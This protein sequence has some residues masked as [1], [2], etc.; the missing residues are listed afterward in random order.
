MADWDRL[1]AQHPTYERLA[2]RYRDERPRKLLALDGGGI[3]GV[4]TLQVLIRM[5]ELLAEE[6]G[7]GQDFRLC[8]FF[9]YIGGTS[10]G[11]IIA[12]GLALG[13]S[14]QELSDFYIA[15]GPEMFE[16]AFILKRLRYL[17][18]KEPLAEE[19]KETYGAAR[20]ASPRT[21]SGASCS[22]SRATS[23]PTRRGPSA[24]TRS[25]RY[26]DLARKDCNLK[27][28]S[29]S[30]CARARPRPSSS[31]PRS[32][33]GTRTTPPSRSSSRTAA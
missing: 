22:S 1:A 23:R 21:R 33:S 9:D 16:K 31:R 19:L 25:P 12:A 11:A 13:M 28:R 10:T 15:T 17:Y 29:G 26:N 7:Q 20:L 5:E 8:N 32:Y 14:A 27:S 2:K 6:S 4:L 18:K 3:R 24:A 30:S